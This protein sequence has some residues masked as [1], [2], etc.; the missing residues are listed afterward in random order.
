MGTIAYYVALCAIAYVCFIAFAYVI[1]GC[2]ILAL[3]LLKEGD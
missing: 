2:F 3:K 1:V